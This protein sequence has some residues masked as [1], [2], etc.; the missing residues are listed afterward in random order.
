[1]II[2]F[3]IILK[4]SNI[5]K[6]Y[7]KSKLSNCYNAKDLIEENKNIYKKIIDDNDINFEIFYFDPD[8]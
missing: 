6:P 8:Y 7:I 5:K 2:Y 1:M 4:H 3:L